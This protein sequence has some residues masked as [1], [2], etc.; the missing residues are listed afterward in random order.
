LPNI[1]NPLTFRVGAENDIGLAQISGMLFTT[2]GTT[3][4]AIMVDWKIKAS[5]PG[6]A[7]MWD[8][9]I[10]AGGAIGTDRS[11]R[12]DC[13]PDLVYNASTSYIYF[14][15]CKSASLMF[16]MTESSSGYFE[17]LWIWTAD[18]D[19][20]SQVDPQE[21]I[22]IYTA[23]GALIESHGPTWFYGGASEHSQMYQW[24]LS[25]ARNI[26]LGHVQSESPYY[27]GKV[28]SMMPFSVKKKS[29]RWPWP[30][31]PSFSDCPLV[32]SSE[33][34]SCLRAWG[35]RIVSS[36]NIWAYSAGIYS[37]FIDNVEDCAKPANA[38]RMSCQDKIIEVEGSSNVNL[39]NVYTI[40]S[41]NV[42]TE[43]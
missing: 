17:N 29:K 34:S 38:A 10:R 14:E 6:E 39:F 16:H 11:T 22:N 7:G 31:D 18:H 2:R 15:K 43:G 32:S 24:Q 4:G 23:R 35:L 40:G 28:K 20:D 12:R 36:R 25:G 42:V 8:T 9:I 19:I 3:P 13:D 33:T 30:D 41:R 27:Q 1:V 21:K 37:F 26:F 5:A